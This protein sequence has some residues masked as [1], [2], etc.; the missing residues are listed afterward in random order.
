MDLR[1]VP[2]EPGSLDVRFDAGDACFREHFPGN[3]VVPGSLITGLCLEAAR[4]LLHGERMPRL[5]RIAFSRFA[6]P[7][8]YRLRVEHGEDGLLCTLSQGET[9]FARGRIEE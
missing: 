6:A 7:G 5:R 9:V 1:P 8:L 4:E 2:G 3:P